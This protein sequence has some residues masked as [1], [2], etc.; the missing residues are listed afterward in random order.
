MVESVDLARRAASQGLQDNSAVADSDLVSDPDRGRGSRDAWF[1]PVLSRAHGMQLY[2]GGT[3]FEHDATLHTV[4]LPITSTGVCSTDCTSPGCMNASRIL[5][6]SGMSGRDL[7]NRNLSVDQIVQGNGLQFAGGLNDRLAEVLREPEIATLSTDEVLD[8]F[9]IS[10]NDFERARSHL[11]EQAS[12]FARD[13][14]VQVPAP[15][16]TTDNP[17]TPATSVFQHFA[18]GRIGPTP[19]PAMHYIAMAHGSL[20]EEDH[21]PMKQ[22]TPVD[23]SADATPSYAARGLLPTIDYAGSVAQW[24]LT[25]NNLGTVGARMN[26]ILGILLAERELTQMVRVEDC[27]RNSPTTGHE[28]RVRVHGV[29]GTDVRVVSGA[30]GL[31]C[32]TTGRVEGQPCLLGDY[33]VTPASGPTPVNHTDR[34]V[35]Y[36]SYV[37]LTFALPHPNP[38]RYYVVRL[39]PG[40]PNTA[41][42]SWEAIGSASPTYA[43]STDTAWRFCHNQP[44]QAATVEEASLAIT[45][46]PED[47]GRPANDCFGAP[48]GPLPLEDELIDNGDAYENSWAHHLQ[49]AQ[50]AAQHADDLGELLI[51]TGLQM[52]RDAEAALSVL[53][54]QCGVRL[55]LDGLFNSS[56][57]GGARA[58]DRLTVP[59]QGGVC[60][61][62]YSQVGPT[63]L[64]SVLSAAALTEEDARGL[65]ECLGADTTEPVVGLGSTRLCLWRE[66]QPGAENILCDGASSTTP[67]PRALRDGETCT[68]PG[69]RVP[70]T[71]DENNGRLLGLLTHQSAAGELLGS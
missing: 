16:L 17:S 51:G 32:A 45:I 36:A 31:A 70:I 60:P 50:A 1:A 68:A 57:V 30:S 55:N 4:E 23:E 39:K 53:E 19:P 11:G 61:P 37:E 69:G 48:M 2:V 24:V 13:L 34:G 49:V 22:S 67:C 3:G 5:E 58:L 14:D 47:C 10:P 18:F 27:Y 26:D 59:P 35:G 40:A 21:R 63:C 62:G 56:G 52:D 7:L 64:L 44:Y 28:L 41:A 29:A 9:E 54:A 66:S 12:L 6:E 46:S 33:Q 25:Q 71:L 43:T 38:I 8:R 20:E 65:A 42:G 15:V